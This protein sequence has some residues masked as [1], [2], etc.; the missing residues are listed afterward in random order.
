MNKMIVSVVV[1]VVVAGGA[2]FYGGMKYQSSKV[3]TFGSGQR[4]FQSGGAGQ[5]R[6][7]ASGGNG[8]VAGE[9]LSKDDKSITLKLPTG[10]S[11][12]VFYSPATTI[13]KTASGSWDD[14]A[15]GTSVLI[16]GTQNADGT[17]TA[18]SVQLS[19]MP[20]RMEGSPAATPK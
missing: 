13:E 10:G 18:Q 8:F 9:V 20:L 4:P 19:R 15:V 7:G 16:R 11:S 5:R 12:I 2:G 14:V 17:Y 6:G 3:P 1:A